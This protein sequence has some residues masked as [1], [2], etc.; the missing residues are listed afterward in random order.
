MATSSSSAEQLNR[1][2]YRCEKVIGTLFGIKFYQS[3][4]ILIY[5]IWYVLKY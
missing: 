1:I 4:K 3:H 2:A 5:Y